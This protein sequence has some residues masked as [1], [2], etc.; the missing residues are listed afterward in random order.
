[1]N[2]EQDWAAMLA[3]AIVEARSGLAEGGL[4][5][6][7]AMFNHQGQLLSSGHNRRV[8]QGDPSVH[9]ETDAFRRAGR[10]RSYRDVI[11]VT[12]LAPCWYCSGLVR[13]FGIGTLVVGE[14]RTFPG[15][16]D[17]LRQAGVQIYD[18]DSQECVALMEAFIR[19][20]PDIWHED[21]GEV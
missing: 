15:G 11:M 4:P 2:G 8:Q 21:I 19:D 1:M 14:S 20:H 3:V 9:A 18:L 7:A 17:W 12:T 16:L 6:G 10:L 5:I 13:Q